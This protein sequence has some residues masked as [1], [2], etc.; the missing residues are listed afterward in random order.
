M[1]V[2]VCWQRPVAAGTVV[3]VVGGI[4]VVVVGAT[5]VEVVELVGG[6]V[7]VVVVLVVVVV[8]AVTV[9]EAALAFQRSIVAQPGEKMPTLAE[10]ASSA[11]PAGTVQG[12]VKVRDTPAVNAWLSHTW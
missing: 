5:V 12:E 4:V 10:C 3:V 1:R 8:E 2:V 11:S 6:T 7:V 9:N